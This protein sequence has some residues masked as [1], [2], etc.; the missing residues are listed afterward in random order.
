LLPVV[1]DAGPWLRARVPAI[2][3]LGTGPQGRPLRGLH[4]TSDRF[5]AVDP[6]ALDLARRTVRAFLA[7]C[8]SLPPAP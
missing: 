1:T 7:R 6:V 8:D 4:Q 3:L 5:A 2:T